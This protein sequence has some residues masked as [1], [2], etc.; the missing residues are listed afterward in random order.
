MSHV[1]INHVYINH[2]TKIIIKLKEVKN[3]LPPSAE[4][5][6]WGKRG[7][8]LKVEHAPMYN[9]YIYNIYI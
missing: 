3:L 8:T 1:Y 9:I 4:K 2:R 7:V 6:H 5:N